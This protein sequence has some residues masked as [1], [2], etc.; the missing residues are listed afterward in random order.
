MP[1][2]YVPCNHKIIERVPN[3]KGKVIGYR[4]CDLKCGKWYERR[5]KVGS[6]PECPKE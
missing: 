4:C 6:E 3:H 2:K 5:C 1:V